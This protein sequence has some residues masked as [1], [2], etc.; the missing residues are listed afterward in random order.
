[1]VSYPFRF[2]EIQLL[3]L[4]P[5]RASPRPELGSHSGFRGKLGTDAKGSAHSSLLQLGGETQISRTAPPCP[6]R[7]R[8]SSSLRCDVP[9][10]PAQTYTNIKAH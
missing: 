10:A 1:M 3:D 5:L 6:L 2:T 7:G 9:S 8:T 4:D